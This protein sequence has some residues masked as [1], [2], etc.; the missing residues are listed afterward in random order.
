[1]AWARP[2]GLLKDAAS[3]DTFYRQFA[4]RVSAVPSVTSV[5]YSSGM[6]AEGAFNATPFTIAGRAAGDRAKRPTARF[7]QVSPAYFETLGIRI[8]RARAFT[9]ADRV[10]TAPVVI[11]NETFVK[12]YFPAVDPLTQR[13]VVDQFNP[14]VTNLGLGIERILFGAFAFVA[15]IGAAFVACLLPAFRAASVDPITALRRE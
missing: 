3:V 1:M 11:V 5:S 12:R 7:N 6:P 4:E 2:D 14:G 8:A 9:D 10:G 13:I 15:L